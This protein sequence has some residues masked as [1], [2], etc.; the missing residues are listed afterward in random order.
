MNPITITKSKPLKLKTHSFEHLLHTYSTRPFFPNMTVNRP[1]IH[2]R[3]TSSHIEIN[4]PITGPAH[5]IVNVRD[6]LHVHLM[7]ILF[8]SKIYSNY[9]SN[10][11]TCLYQKYY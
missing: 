9:K 2:K 10:I 5:N 4:S 7:I 8:I 1:N 3:I 11:R 6:F